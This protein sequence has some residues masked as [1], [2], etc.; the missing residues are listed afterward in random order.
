MTDEELMV[1]EIGYLFFLANFNNCID[2]TEMLGKMA[3]VKLKKIE[4]FTHKDWLKGCKKMRKKSK[5]E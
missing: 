3:G 4:K 1:K 2:T 5:E